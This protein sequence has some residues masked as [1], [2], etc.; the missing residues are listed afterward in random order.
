LLANTGADALQKARDLIVQLRAGASFEDLAKANSIDTSNASRGGDLGFFGAGQM[1]R[2]FEEAVNK[3]AKPGDI[4]DPV[5]TQFGYHI[6][7]LEE[8][9]ENGRQSYEEVRSQLV[10]EART[11]ILNESRVTK[12]QSM[13]KDVVFERA[14]IEALA[15]S[16][17]R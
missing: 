10:D 3:L 14:T 4:S 2:P 1:V 8:R 13:M 6:V 17:A 15:K 12:V 16:P 7:R 9:R 11:A 5:E